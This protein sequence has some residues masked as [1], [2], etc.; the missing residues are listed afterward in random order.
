[1][2]RHRRLA[3]AILC[4]ATLMTILDGTIVTVALPTIQARLGF[5]AGGLSWVMNSYLIAFGGLLLLSGRLGDLIGRKRV[6]LAGIAAFT[7]ASLACGLAAGPGTLIAARFVQGA[8]AA[9]A[10]SVTL[11]MIVRLSDQPQEQSKAVGVFAFT[12]AVGA[13]AGLIIGGLLVQYASWRWIFLVN[14]PVG[15]MTW[16]AGSRAL[17][18]DRGIG[19][20]AGA[21]VLGALLATSGVMLAV[22]AIA[23]PADWWAGLIAAALLAGFAARQATARTPLL[24]PRVLAARGV[25][26]TN[27]AQL[28]VIGAAMGFQVVVT[29]YM[30]RALGYRPAAAGLGLVPTAAVIAVVSLGLSAR[31]TARFGARRL[32]LAGLVMITLALAALT[33]VPAHAGYATWLLPPLL[34]FGAGGGLALP[35]LAALG[36]SGATDA[37]AGVVSGLFNTTQQVGAAIGVALLTSLAARQAGGAASAQALTSGYQLAFATGAGLGAASI[38]VAAVT[39]RPR[40]AAGA[41]GDAGRVFAGRVSEPSAAPTERRPA[42]AARGE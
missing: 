17:A 3:L 30:Q 26:G 29:L 23:T 37:D 15:A 42:P 11:A 2:S 31:L 22:F 1:M 21:D 6:F 25:A 28:L 24:P 34:L 40:R 35:S 18:A 38:A 19:S 33:Q 16:L 5:T 10:S 36:M 41:A 9:M 12:G 32:L 20:R 14:L 8:G 4:A 27:V 7:V 13:S 39:L